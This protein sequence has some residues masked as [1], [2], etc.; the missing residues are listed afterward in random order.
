MSDAAVSTLLCRLRLAGVTSLFLEVST[1]AEDIR[2]ESLSVV[3]PDCVIAMRCDGHRKQSCVLLDIRQVF[4][5]GPNVVVSCSRQLSSL[6]ALWLQC[7]AMQ[8]KVPFE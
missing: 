3:S 4:N 5:V 6:H 2:L 8:C 7:N 1:K